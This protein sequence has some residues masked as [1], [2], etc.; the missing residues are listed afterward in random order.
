MILKMLFLTFFNANLRF[1][2]KKLIYRSY[3]TAKVRPTTSNI[4]LIDNK[5]FV[6]PTLDENSE[7]FVMHVAFILDIILIHLVRGAQIALLLAEKT[8]TKI[9]AEYSDYANVFSS[10]LTIELPKNTDMN[11]HTIELEDDK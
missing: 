10:D 4:E 1:A 8:P 5:K 6:K 7:S 11:N 2:E 9:L 3:M